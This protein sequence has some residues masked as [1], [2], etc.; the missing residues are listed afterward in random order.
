MKFV[1]ILSIVFVIAMLSSLFV[2]CAGVKVEYGI[3]GCFEKKVDN[4]GIPT[5]PSEGE[6]TQLRHKVTAHLK[7]VDYKGRELYYTD[8]EDPFQYDS[9]YF[10]PTVIKF[11]QNY[12]DMNDKKLS[13]EISKAGIISSISIT[14]KGQT[15]K[16]AAETTVIS[17][18]DG[19]EQKT[20]WVC[21][22]NGEIVAS[23]KET[24]VRD[25]DV[26]ELRLVYPDYDKEPIISDPVDQVPSNPEA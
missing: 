3:K 13:C 9:A 14:K 6:E 16:Y 23:M 21:Y 12:A 5:G 7:V 26:V 25:G 4:S 1:K 8:A 18:Y 11:V 17:E 2:S 15:V 19:S 10:E 20:Y 24:I 22:I